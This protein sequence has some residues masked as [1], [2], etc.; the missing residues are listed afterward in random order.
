[1]DPKAS[2]QEKMAN[3]PMG[4]RQSFG[5]AQRKEVEETRKVHRV[6]EKTVA[7]RILAARLG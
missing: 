2:A 4:R 5:A 6:D 1:M 3:A 7:G